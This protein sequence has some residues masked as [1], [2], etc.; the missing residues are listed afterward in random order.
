MSAPGRNDPCPCGSG[1]KYKRCHGASPASESAGG[2]RGTDRSRAVQALDQ[3]LVER[4]MRFD[5][6]RYGKPWFDAM[7]RAYTERGSTALH[8]DEV[9]LAL[10]WS[11]F[12]YREDTADACLAERFQREQGRRL[13]RDLSALLDAQLAAWCSLWIVESVDAGTGLA[14][15]DLLSHEK[16]FV[17]ERLASASLREGHVVLAR[18]V[19]ADG[20]SFLAGLHPQG[21]TEEGAYDLVLR[22]RKR[23]R[24]RTRAVPLEA[25]RSAET[26]RWLIG[27]WRVLAEA[28]QHPPTLHNTDGDL[29]EPTVDLLEFAAADRDEVLG[30]LAQ[31]EGAEEPMPSD[32]GDGTEIVI[33]RPD[34]KSPA[35]GPHTVLGTIHVEAGRLRITTNS[36]RRADRLRKSVLTATAPLVRHRLREET[37]IA[38]ML[39]ELKDSVD[40]KG[41]TPVL[42][43]RHAMTPEQ[44][45]VVRRQKEVHYAAWPDDA[46]PALGGATPRASMRTAAGRER[47][48]MLVRR[49]ERGEAT[50]PEAE[51][52]DVGRLRRELGL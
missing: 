42:P 5:R 29:L 9:Q 24:V 23:C 25:L 26:Q 11:F 34:A 15:R 47:V 28:L 43:I 39:E 10:P 36:T 17:H 31:V 18:V 12:S 40:S 38:R 7:V 46:L 3:R 13:D 16:R 35:D 4:L 14:L 22:A 49:I 45:A 8:D 30:R 48:A 21:S 44:Q 27:E 19:D 37:S 41:G 20:I 1:V 33:T 2:V 50:L 52:F 6:L 32:E 51:R